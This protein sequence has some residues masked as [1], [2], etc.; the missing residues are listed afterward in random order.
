MHQILSHILSL[1]K[2]ALC[3]EYEYSFRCDPGSEIHITFTQEPDKYIICENPTPTVCVDARPLICYRRP[4]L[5]CAEYD[6]CCTRCVKCCRN[7]IT[8]DLGPND[9]II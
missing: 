2:M 4:V 1:T 5:C 6:L 9:N 7:C 8:M 3:C